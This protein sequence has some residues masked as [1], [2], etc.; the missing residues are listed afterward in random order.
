MHS[1]P[2]THPCAETQTCAP[3]QASDKAAEAA[4]RALRQS[5]EVREQLGL[6][7]KGQRAM[8][9]TIAT[10]EDQLAEAVADVLDHPFCLGVTVDSDY[11]TV[12]ADNESR[13]CFEAQLRGDIS[14]ALQVPPSCLPSMALQVT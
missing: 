9:D 1:P 11:E 4:A 3:T 5:H 8:R 6:V 13:L 12:M 10:L 7:Q 14:L 2:L